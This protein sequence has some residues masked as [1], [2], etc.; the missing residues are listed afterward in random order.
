MVGAYDLVG[1]PD[2][3]HIVGLGGGRVAVDD[4]LDRQ[5]KHFASSVA[6]EGRGGLARQDEHD[7]ARDVGHDVGRDPGVVFSV[8]GGGVVVVWLRGL[9]LSLGIV[10]LSRAGGTLA[11]VCALP[12][13]WLLVS[14][15]CERLDHVCLPGCC[16]MAR[17]RGSV[18]SRVVVGESGTLQ[19]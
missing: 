16:A 7:G 15:E 11:G 5:G 14:F 19:H 13:L 10:I 6:G 17:C 18:A 12:L 8:V 1:N 4:V 3:A 9:E 2:L